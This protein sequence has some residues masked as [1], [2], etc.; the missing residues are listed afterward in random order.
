MWA[1]QVSGEVHSAQVVNVGYKGDGNL[2]IAT[3][4]RALQDYR[5]V[6]FALVNGEY[7]DEGDVC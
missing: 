5:G 7:K 1:V 3:G 2:H 4:V 6:C